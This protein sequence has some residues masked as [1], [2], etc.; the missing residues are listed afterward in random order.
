MPNKRLAAV[1]ALF[2]LIAAL[3]ALAGAYPSLYQY[4]IAA[5]QQAPRD[6]TAQQPAQQPEDAQEPAN[7]APAPQ[8]ELRRLLKAL[9]KR[10]EG[11]PQSVKGYALNGYAPATALSAAGGQSA[12]ARLEGLYGGIHI[13]PR[14]PVRFGRFLYPEELEG[15]DSKVVLDE[16]LAIEL[17]RTSDP[18]G[19]TLTIG[20]KPYTVVGVLRHTRTAGDQ[21]HAAAYVPLLALEKQGLQTQMLCVSLLSSFAAG[22]L[23]FVQKQL[24]QWM[25]GGTFYSLAKERYR[26]LLPVR[27]L[28]CAI[29]VLAVSIT[30]R[31]SIRFGRALWQQLRGKMQRYYPGRLVG[32][33]AFSLLAV[34]LLTAAHVGAAYLLFSASIDPVYVFPEWVPTILVEPDDIIKAFWNNITAQ[35]ALVALRTPQVL[36][37]G[38][39]HRILT[40][41]CAL[42]LALV[43]RP[44][45]SWR[46]MD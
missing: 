24:E 4:C 42:A 27:W 16:Q 14:Q 36:A 19:R 8:S 26:A 2:L 7:P 40:A 45:A 29:G 9:D 15:G 3:S 22:D 39:Y 25:A 5:P 41:L 34:L 44:L 28:L 11:L 6:D 10:L 1:I 37:L 46:H 21:E 38:F 13:L 18:T 31:W 23:A 33:M 43:V 17:F 35:T 20:E 12:S 30:W 32:R